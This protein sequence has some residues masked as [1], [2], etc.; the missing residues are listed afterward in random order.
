M[1]VYNK[2]TYWKEY[3]LDEAEQEQAMLRFATILQD[4]DEY[5]LAYKFQASARNFAETLY[6]STRRFQYHD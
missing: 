3:E 1:K 4:I 6:P 5:E 2:Q